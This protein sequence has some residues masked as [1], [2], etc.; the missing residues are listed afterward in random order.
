MP[1]FVYK[2]ES[3]RVLGVHWAKDACL[4]TIPSQYFIIL[5]HCMHDMSLR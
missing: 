4:F 3:H 5:G 1:L 2:G